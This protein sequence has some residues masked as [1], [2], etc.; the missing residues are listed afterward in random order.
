M[1][2]G[3]GGQA[4]NIKGFNAAGTINVKRFVALTNTAFSVVQA[5]A[6]TAAQ[7]VIGIVQDYS[8]DRSTNPVGSTEGVAASSGQPVMVH[9]VGEICLLQLGS[10][11]ATV[12][13]GLV[14]DANG[15]GVAAS[16]NAGATHNA[17]AL[18]TGAEDDFIRVLVNGQSG[19]AIA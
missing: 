15:K 2:D 16:T 6:V 1:A 11:G 4:R 9:G 14:P 19:R 18:E 12:G 13:G 3:Y 8:R 5:V 17:Y 7:F 10:G